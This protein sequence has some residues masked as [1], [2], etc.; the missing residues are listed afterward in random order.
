MSIHASLVILLTPIVA[1]FSFLFLLC[2]LAAAVVCLLCFRRPHSKRVVSMVP[3]VGLF[4]GN[5]VCVC[6]S[7]VQSATSRQKA[8]MKTMLSV[9]AVCEVSLGYCITRVCLAAR[10][11]LSVLHV[12]VLSGWCWFG[13]GR[14]A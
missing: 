1:F 10:V 12:G 7:L 9:D 13:A 11:V 6:L 5:V 14:V 2:L 3:A 4:L 8:R